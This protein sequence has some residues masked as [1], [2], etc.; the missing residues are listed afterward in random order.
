MRTLEVLIENYKSTTAGL[1]IFGKIIVTFVVALII[2]SVISAFI[3][4]ALS[5]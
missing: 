1:N 4:I 3:N 2:I 5:I